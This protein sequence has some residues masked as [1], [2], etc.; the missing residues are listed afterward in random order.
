MARCSG[1]VVALAGV[2]T[3][4]LALGAPVAAQQEPPAGDAGTVRVVEISGYLDPILADFLEDSI[5]AANDAG[6][7]ALV[8]QVNSRQATVSDE[9]L[10]ELASAIVASDVFV[11]AWVGPSGSVATG[12]VA[13]LL[14]VVDRVVVTVG[15]DIGD[16]GPPV[17]DEARFGSLWGDNDTLLRNGTLNWEQAIDRGVVSCVEVAIDP[18]LLPE[19]VDPERAQKERCA[20][21]LG[22]FILDLPGVASREVEIEGI[23]RREPLTSVQFSGVSLLDQVFH[24][25]ASPP[26]AYLMF[27]IGMAL[28][29]FEFYS[30]GIGIAGAIG[31]IFLLLGTY[32]LAVVPHRTWA[33]VLLVLAMVAFAID[34]QTA[35]PR[36]WTAIGTA[37]FAVGT[38]SLFSDSMVSMSWIPMLV[39][40]AGMA[41]VMWRGMPIMVRGRFA[42]T[43]VP[44]DFLDGAEGVVA[45]GQTVRIANASWPADLDGAARVGEKV[46][47]T[48]SS[49]P[50]LRCRRLS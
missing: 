5:E 38:I 46:L 19:G 41:V 28:I 39:G 10:N 30:A 42:T 21:T 36:A 43:A 48:G 34:I 44:R 33:L 6:A 22:D 3:G 23:P 26:V 13:Q 14:A 17:L 37:L 35:V 20:A 15:S 27:I 8:L 24:T 7:V 9:R 12:K 50:V 32:G 47:V 25:V 29:V 1:P 18:A 16:T 49:G 45:P 31:A 40:I 4:L 2:A 11:A